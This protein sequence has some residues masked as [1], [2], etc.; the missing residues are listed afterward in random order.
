MGLYGRIIIFF[1]YKIINI[2]WYEVY[3]GEL[4]DLVSDLKG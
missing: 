2:F 1:F 3:V 4:C